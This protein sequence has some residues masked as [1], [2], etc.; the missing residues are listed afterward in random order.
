MIEKCDELYLLVII[1]LLKINLCMNANKIN[2]VCDFYQ[3]NLLIKK[4][5]VF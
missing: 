5:S 2:Y 1:S 3:N 4:A